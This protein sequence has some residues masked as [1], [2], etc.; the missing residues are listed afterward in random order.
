M[1]SELSGAMVGQDA[2][3]VLNEQRNTNEDGVTG[4]LVT[5]KTQDGA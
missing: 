4:E 5:N 3:D 1:H 2:E